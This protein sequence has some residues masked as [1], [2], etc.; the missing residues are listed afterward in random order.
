MQVILIICV[1]VTVK[2]QILGVSELLVAETLLDDHYMY[3]N[4]QS[5]SQV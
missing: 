2:W 5:C 4:L 3:M 1:L